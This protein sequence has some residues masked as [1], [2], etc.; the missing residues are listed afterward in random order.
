[1]KKPLSQQK[2]VKSKGSICPN[3]RSKN[4]SAD[5]P[6]IDG[7]IVWVNVSCQDCEACWTDIYNLIGYDSLETLIEE[8]K[9]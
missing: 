5:G 4:I 7:E 8:N 6:E 1:M 9:E 3:C 2:Y